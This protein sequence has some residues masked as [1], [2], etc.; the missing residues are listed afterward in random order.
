[1]RLFCILLVVALACAS[2]AGAAAQSLADVARKEEARRKNVKTSSRVLT[3][4]DLKPSDSPFVPVPPPPAETPAAA[5]PA[6]PAQA[7]DPA[8]KPADEEQQREDEEKAWRQK[9]ADARTALERSQ[10][11]HDALQSKINALWAEFTGKDDYAQRAVL[12]VERKRAIAE[13]E[14]VTEE[15][16]QQKKAIADLEEEARR[17]GVPPG[18][19]R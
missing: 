7:Q 9:M 14:R 4:K 2:A 16:A 15:I 12:E 13:Q 10:M 8:D 19:L 3:N 18:W 5:A 6:D 1:M 17:E 11:Y